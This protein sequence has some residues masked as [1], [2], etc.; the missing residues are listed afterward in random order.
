[1]YRP[2]YYV[3][4][5]GFTIESPDTRGGDRFER[6]GEVTNQN[7]LENLL[8]EPLKA[9]VKAHYKKSQQQ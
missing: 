9:L 1:V 7:D 4:R 8:A 5:D 6:S 3:D 2:Y